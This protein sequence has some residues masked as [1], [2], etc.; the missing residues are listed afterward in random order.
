MTLFAMNNSPDWNQI[1]TEKAAYLLMDWLRIYSIHAVILIHQQSS[2]NF[3]ATDDICT[4]DISAAYDIWD[5][6]RE[7]IRKMYL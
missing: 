6:I 2:P 7:I 3:P 1:K 5:S 4:T